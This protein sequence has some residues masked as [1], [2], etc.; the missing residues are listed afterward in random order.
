MLRPT[1]SRPLSLGIKPPSGAYDQISITLTQLRVCWCGVSSLTRGR[2]CH[3]QFLLVLASAVIFGSESRR[4]RDHILLSPVRDFPLRRLLRLAGIRWRY[5][6]PPPRW[7]DFIRIWTACYI[8][9]R[10]PRKY[11][12]LAR[13]HGSVFRDELVFRNLSLR[14]SVCQ[15]VS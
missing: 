10:Y 12:L 1:V 2:V 9:Y 14:K 4:T 3:L 8:A 15:L 6:T 7:N 5:S 13:I 11:L